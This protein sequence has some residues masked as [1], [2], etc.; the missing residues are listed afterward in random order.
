[1]TAA[2][3]GST[4]AVRGGR[5]D[6]ER[7]GQT[8]TKR[9]RAPTATT[10]SAVAMNVLRGTITSSPGPIPRPARISSSASVPL[11]TP[12]QCPTPQ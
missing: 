10:A 8:S 3:A 11:A 7:V 9:G 2:V 4:A 12:T 1:M 6:Q 5:I